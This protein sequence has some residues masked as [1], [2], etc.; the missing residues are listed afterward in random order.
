[1]PSTFVPVPQFPNVPNLPGVPPLV[2]SGLSVGSAVLSIL[3]G[4]DPGLAAQA[5]GP[6]W[7][8]FDTNNNPLV[9]PDSVFAFSLVDDARIEK[10]PIEGGS[11]MS[12]NKVNEPFEPR[13]TMTK[14]GAVADRTGF[15]QAL[16]ALKVSIAVCNVVTPEITYESV[17]CTHVDFDRKADNG[18]TLI[19]ADVHFEQV[20]QTGTVAFSNTAQPS[21]A[22]Q[23]NDGQVQPLGPTPEQEAATAPPEGT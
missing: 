1:M 23:V 22:S 6:Q 5:S 2:R 8:V 18:A 10:Y 16:R 11:F 17:N 12:Y 9:L 20:N 19:T 21:G 13:L 4:D 3:T 7:G 15:I 14:G